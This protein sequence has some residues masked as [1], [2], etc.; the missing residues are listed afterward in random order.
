[1]EGAPGNAHRPSPD[2]PAATAPL[3][4][5]Q[6]FGTLAAVIVA[7]GIAIANA[8]RDR[9]RR[10]ALSLT[11]NQA[12]PLDFMMG[13]GIGMDMGRERQGHWMRLRVAN[14]WGKRSADDVEVLVI[15]VRGISPADG[16]LLTPLLGVLP[17]KWSRILDAEGRPLTRT[18]IPPGVERHVDLL[19]IL[20][21][22]PGLGPVEAGKV[23]AVAAL[24]VSPAPSDRRHWLL[25]GTYGILLA[26]TARDT[27]ATY[28]GL[29]VTYDGK[30]WPAPEMRQHLTVS[31]PEVVSYGPDPDEA[32]RRFVRRNF[33]P[34]ERV[35]RALQRANLVRRWR[36]R[37][38]RASVAEFNE[39]Y[40]RRDDR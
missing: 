14:A 15:N 20:E 28:Y 22:D 25:G 32:F 38:L 2:P 29:T 35:G 7:L 6:A 39:R 21:P 3:D 40:G 19:R 27:D 16:V 23:S 31:P 33:T 13:V 4:W 24:Q 10:P 37:R 36:L 26:V 11:C 18:T 17:L 9:R 30:W 12:S 1:V 8:R 5:L 34:R